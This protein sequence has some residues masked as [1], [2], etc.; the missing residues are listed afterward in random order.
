M[1][2]RYQELR[3]ALQ[4]VPAFIEEPQTRL[5]P[6]AE[7]NFKMWNPADDAWIHDGKIINGDENLSFDKAVE[8]LKTIY[9]NRLK[10]IQDSL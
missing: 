5:R 4:T 8:R 6:S 1:K 9:E 7:L 2:A 3:P 10:V